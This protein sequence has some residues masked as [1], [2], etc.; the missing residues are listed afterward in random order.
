LGHGSAV[1]EGDPHNDAQRY[2]PIG[3]YALISDCHSAALVSRDGSIDWCCFHR[4][5]A[6]PVFCRLLDWDRGGHCRIA[7][8]KP[9]RS[10]RRYLPGTNV[11]ETRFEA[12][13]GVMT[14]TDL[15]PIRQSSQADD[16]AAVHPYH[17]LIRLVRCEAGEI[18]VR[19]EF[20][21]RYDYGYTTP[22]LTIR[23]AD[24]ATVFGGADALLLQTDLS[25]DQ[26]D[27]GSC[28]GS[29]RLHAGQEA[30]VIVTYAIPHELRLNRIDPEECRRRIDITCRFWR[31]WSDRC[32]YQ[33]PYREQVVRSALVL[34]GLTNAPNGALVAAP[35]TSLPEDIGGVRNW[36]YRYTWLRDSSFMLYALFSL[37]YTDEA[38]AFM[39]WLQRTTAGRA[40]DLQVLYGVG[41]ERFLPELEL[42]QLEGYRGSRPVRVGNHAT[43]QFQLD[44]YGEVMDTAWLYHR[45]GGKIAPEFWDFLVQIVEHVH[46]QWE[47]PDEGIWE[48]RGG[49][50]QFVYSKVMA[51]VAVDRALKLANAR[52][53]PA[54][55]ER[56]TALRD[57][58][59]QRIESEGV[60]Q[61][62]SAFVQ[63]FGSTAM[64]ASNLL[65]PLIHFLPPQDPR[66]AATIR[67][68]ERRLS[69]NGLVYRYLET[70]DGLPGGEA[71]FAI[72]SFW[73][74]DNLVLAGQVERGR[75]LFERL[76]GYLND[77]GLLAEQIDPASGEHVGNFPQAFSHLG[78]ISSAL[79]LGNADHRSAAK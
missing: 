23:G 70:D 32:T 59:R 75:T 15:F 4:F 31:E 8:A 53:L 9:Y 60:D 14:V 16:P 36:D 72:C 5:D 30:S 27:P 7:P 56:W 44:I 77:V 71:T 10:S 66:I 33:G 61:A 79:Q 54:D 45:Y 37:G 46:G 41:G 67:E 47:E 55:T 22:Q 52:N 3:N 29:R 26:S 64:D 39:Q 28:G 50:R 58:I 68:V 13:G 69:R 34:K 24:L 42:D 25:M 35:T 51:W 1:I 19:F 6:R 74:V 38:H 11:L 18:E 65:L 17:Q 57:A 49:R 78:L 2:P 40:R 21:P 43:T 63:S 48:V 76:L 20:A 73:L 62:T 12:E